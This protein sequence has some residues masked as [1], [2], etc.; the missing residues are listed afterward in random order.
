MQ[1]RWLSIEGIKAIHSELIERYGGSPGLRD[2]NL[3]ASAQMRPIHLHNYEPDASV[4]RLTA[5]LGWGLVK[6]HA[7]VDGNKRIALATMVTF[8][9]L[10]H[11]ELDCSEAEETAMVL[12]AAASEISE[13]QWN[14][15]FQGTVR[16]KIS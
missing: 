2:E 11:H 14:V 1:L 3:L 6:N 10:N 5:S 12:R 8:L 16:A 9:E 15:W 7:F 4:A 13:E